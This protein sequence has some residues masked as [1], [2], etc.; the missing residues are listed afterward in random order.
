LPFHNKESF[1]LPIVLK[2]SE[3]L[4]SGYLKAIAVFVT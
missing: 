4:L 1:R 3:N 2:N